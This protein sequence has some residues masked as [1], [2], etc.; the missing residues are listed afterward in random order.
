M[1]C[2]D[3]AP[4][5]GSLGDGSLA[6][7]EDRLLRAHLESCATCR[8]AEDRLR[9]LERLLGEG[10][11]VPDPGAAYFDA[12]R[13]RLIRSAGA[14]SA[15]PAAAQVRQPRP[16]RFVWAAAA[17]T[18]LLAAG[19]VTYRGLPGRTREVVPGALAPS[20]S[21]TGAS[22]PRSGE[23]S[24]R[25]PD[26]GPAPEQRASGKAA[27]PALPDP[28]PGPK[29]VLPVPSPLAKELP[30]EPPKE[31]P[32]EVPKEAPSALASGASARLAAMTEEAVSIG[33]AETPRDRVVALFQAAEARLGEL[34]QVMRADPALASELASAYLLLLG[35]GVAS[36]LQD[37]TESS[38]DLALA[39]GAAREHARGHERTLAGLEAI[40]Q[41]TLKGTLEEALAMSRELARP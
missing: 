9:K 1:T 3:V 38:Q 13:E 39:R 25:F 15:S 24:P 19:A 2:K 26:P 28:S 37:K 29:P 41:G 5:L 27:L 17:A 6:A 36:V 20:A 8:G 30:I 16:L 32:R 23:E 14:G 31:V 35:E 11:R 40:A 12:Q 22:G 34:G 10:L 7:S 21:G 18:V 4:L 33:L